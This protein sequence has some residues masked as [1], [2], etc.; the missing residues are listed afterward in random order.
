MRLF[1]LWSG[2]LSARPP[3]HASARDCR[4]SEKRLAQPRQRPASVSTCTQ[5]R[6]GRS[7]MPDCFERGDFHWP[8]H[9]QLRPRSAARARCR[10]NPPP[11][12]G[13]A[14][15]IAGGDGVGGRL[16]VGDHLLPRFVRRPALSSPPARVCRVIGW[17]AP[18]GSSNTAL[19]DA[20]AR[21][22]QRVKGEVVLH[23]QRRVRLRSPHRSRQRQ[24]R[25]RLVLATTGPR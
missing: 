13:R 18:A 12:R 5:I 24:R 16:V 6:L 21:N 14:L 20:R 22:L 25:L 10:Q 8:A 23:Q 4:R 7:A 15:R 3:A 17:G 1:S 19:R 2:T 11:S 9:V